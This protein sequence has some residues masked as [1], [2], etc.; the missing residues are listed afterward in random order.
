MVSALGQ[1]QGGESENGSI[2]RDGKIF[3]GYYKSWR[4]LSK[5][6]KDKVDAE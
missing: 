6:D 2:Y 4:E 5:E 3:T 1:H